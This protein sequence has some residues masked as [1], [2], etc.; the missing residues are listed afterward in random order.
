MADLAVM[1][2]VLE[3]AVIAVWDVEMVKVAKGLSHNEIAAESVASAK[4]AAFDQLGICS[5][6][7]R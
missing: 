4:H 2:G 1:A 3:D 6:E 7:E 5:E